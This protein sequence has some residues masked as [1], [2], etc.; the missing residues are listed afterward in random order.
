MTDARDGVLTKKKI[1]RKIAF[2]EFHW[3]PVPVVEKIVN[4]IFEEMSQAI[5]EGRTVNLQGFGKIHAWV[6]PPRR[7]LNVVMQEVGL[8]P[9][10]YLVH[11]EPSPSLRRRGGFDPRDPKGEDPF[12]KE[13]A[14]G[15]PDRKRKP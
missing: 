2:E 7:S 1:A 14:A 13:R 3:L 15:L 10:S 6:K 8:W 11:W 9:E 4:V 5:V 12:Q